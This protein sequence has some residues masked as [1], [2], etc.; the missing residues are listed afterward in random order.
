MNPPPTLAE[1]KRL[2]DYDPLTG[3]FT[4][5]VYRNAKVRPGATAGTVNKRGYRYICVNGCQLQAHRLAFFYMTG[6]WP[7]EQIDHQH[8]HR[9]DNRW[10][11]LRDLPRA[12]NNQNIVR[13]HA[14]NKTGFLGVVPAPNGRFDAH[15]CTNGKRK[16]LGR[17]NTGEEAHSVYLAAKRE[18]HQGCTL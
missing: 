5:R 6:A 1:L 8:G 7:S 9:D 12:I 14:D 17:F 18:L 10:S 13:P 15:I 3:K 16:Y 11:E 4:W 2:L